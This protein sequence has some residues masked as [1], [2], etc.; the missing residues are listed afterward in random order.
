MTDRTSIRQMLQVRGSAQEELFRTAR[1]ARDQAWGSVALLRGVVELT[2]VCRVNC[3]YCPMRRDNVAENDRYFISADDVVSRAQ[4]IRDAGI[5][6]VLLQGGETPALLPLLEEAIP[7]IV[8]LF[9]GRV[10]VL[11]NVGNL[12]AEQ[13]ARLRDAGATSYIIKHETSDPELHRLIR[14]E[15]LA[16]RLECFRTLK[17][18]G[19][20][21]GT[22]L[23]S[24]LPGQGLD[25]IVDDI[26]LAGELEADMCSVSPFIPAPN[27]PLADAATGDPDLALNVI[28]VLRILYPHLLIP[29][30]SAL[31]KAGDGGQARGLMAGANVM[32]V[33]FSKPSDQQRYLIYGKDRYIVKLDHVRAIARSAGL[34]FRGSSFI[35]QTRSY[36]D[37]A[38]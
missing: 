32:T 2:N 22:G 34:H 24:N 15:S 9:D 37:A 26:L 6:I 11:L 7:R 1:I 29:S 18:L 23:I 38:Q 30:V 5:N 25:S 14:H 10:E 4:A 8:E 28:A 12:R 35:D 31:E 16:D 33:N 20:R 17:S 13:Y 19:F 21:V 36:E 27:T 3:D